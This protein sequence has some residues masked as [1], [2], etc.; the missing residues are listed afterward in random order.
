LSKWNGAVWNM[1][2]VGITG[3]TIPTHCGNAGGNPYTTL[4]T[5]P[6]IAEKPYIMITPQ[7]TFVLRVPN[8][9]FGK[10]GPTTNFDNAVDHDFSEVYV[11]TQSDSAAAINAKLA[12]GLHVILS[13]GNYQL[14]AALSITHDNTVVLGIGF[15]TL[16]ATT[17]NACISVGDANGV[18]VGG[19]IVQGGK[20]H[21]QTLIQWGA[22]KNFG[23]PKN[24]GFMY[25]I[26]ARIGGTND[27]SQYQVSV[28]AV[29]TV[30]HRNAVLD[31]S[32]LWRADHDITGNVVNSTNPSK[33]GFVVNGDF[34]TAYALAVEHHLQDGVV[35]N[36]ESG[37]TFFYQCELPYDVTQ[38]NFGDPGYAGY[39]VSPTVKN[40]TAYGVGVYSFF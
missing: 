9:E 28:D 18:R 32:W 38:Q 10:V 22:T 2:F 25:D 39:R 14:E 26:F 30:N 17:G 8:V 7:G 12:L 4:Q 40:H 16:T 27:P 23:D 13:P 24:P 34:V 33:N 37:E 11:A 29:L 1:V 35:W 19:I 21:S 31:N 20:Q 36:G 15:P 3:T 5:A 6:V